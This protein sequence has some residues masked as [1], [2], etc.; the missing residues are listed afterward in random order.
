VGDRWL[1]IGLARTVG[2]R[3]VL[4]RTGYGRLEEARPPADVQ[5]DA[6]VNNLIEAVGW[7]LSPRKRSADL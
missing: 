2:A 5:A 7:M 6:I 3:G 4:V 1:D